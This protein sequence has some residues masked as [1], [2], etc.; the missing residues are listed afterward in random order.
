MIL[1]RIQPAARPR[2]ILR[3]LHISASIPRRLAA[4]VYDVIAVFTVLY[5]ASFVPVL[6]VGGEAITS[7]NPLFILYLL[8]I[9]FGYFGACWTRGRTLGMQAWQ[10][11][12]ESTAAARHIN[13][14]ESLIRFV[15]AAL[16]LGALGLGYIAAVFDPERRTWHDRISK[17]RLVKRT[18]RQ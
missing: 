16:S 15:A 14:G 3:P 5:F 2:I 13:W 7:G 8:S 4:L 6:A 12:L 9:A 18:S 17:S 10:L 11:E 1:K